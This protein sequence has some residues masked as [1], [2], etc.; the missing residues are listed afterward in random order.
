MTLY[1]HLDIRL[2]YIEWVHKL[3]SESLRQ[4]NIKLVEFI[5]DSMMIGGYGEAGRSKRSFI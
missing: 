3:K 2:M 5:D 1:V 4:V